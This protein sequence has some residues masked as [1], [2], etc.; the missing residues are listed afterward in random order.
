MD[1]TLQNESRLLSVNNQAIKWSAMGDIP[2]QQ[3]KSLFSVDDSVDHPTLLLV[4][5]FNELSG[6]SLAYF[7]LEK[8]VNV[9]R[10]DILIIMDSQR[11][12]FHTTGPRVESLITWRCTDVSKLSKPL[13][14]SDEAAMHC[15]VAQ[16]T[17][18]SRKNGL[19]A[20]FQV[21]NV[22]AFRVGAQPLDQGFPIAS[23]N[24]LVVH[25]EDKAIPS[26]LGGMG[27]KG[28]KTIAPRSKSVRR[29]KLIWHPFPPKETS[30]VLKAYKGCPYFA[31]M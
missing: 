31:L 2:S 26:L 27:R 11:P 29:C 17:A 20:Q 12:L 16:P 14:T 9:D 23:D 15:Y 8:T 21:L 10:V 13:V 25:A 7:V 22:L 19:A 30:H 28:N 5:H 4:S 3:V 24:M 1:L 18:A 6:V